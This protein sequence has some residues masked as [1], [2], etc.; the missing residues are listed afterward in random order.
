MLYIP[1]ICGYLKILSDEEVKNFAVVSIS[2]YFKSKKK[3][4]ILN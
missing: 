4:C 3:N 2:E 1:K